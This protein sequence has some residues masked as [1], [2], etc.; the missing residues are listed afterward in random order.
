[1]SASLSLVKNSRRT[2]NGCQFVLECL[3]TTIVLGD[4]PDSVTQDQ[5]LQQHRNLCPL[6]CRCQ[7]VAAAVGSHVRPATPALH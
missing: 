4:I 3:M 2:L 5:L 1:M 7:R 6:H